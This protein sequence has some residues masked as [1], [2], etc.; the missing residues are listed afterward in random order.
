VLW[1]QRGNAMYR[2]LPQGN[3]SVPTRF[4]NSQ[5]NAYFETTNNSFYM[6]SPSFSTVLNAI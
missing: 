4:Y 1:I 6:G 5:L 3:G 2:L